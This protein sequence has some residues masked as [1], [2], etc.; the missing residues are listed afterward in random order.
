MLALSE[1]AAQV[2]PLGRRLLKLVTVGLAVTGRLSQVQTDSNCLYKLSKRLCSF[3]SA[4]DS[5]STTRRR[6]GTSTF[7]KRLPSIPTLVFLASATG[8]DMVRHDES[9]SPQS[10]CIP[11]L[12]LSCRSAYISWNRKRMEN[13]LHALSYHSLP[14]GHQD[15]QRMYMAHPVPKFRKIHLAE[16]WHQH[17]TIWSRHQSKSEH[18]KI[19]KLHCPLTFTCLHCHA[20]QCPKMWA[21]SAG[22]A[23]RST[24]HRL[25]PQRAIA[26][27]TAIKMAKD[28]LSTNSSTRRPL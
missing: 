23:K 16:S 15:T 3:Q 21:T 28:G 10:T 7:Q 12:C 13:Q 22:G 11:S 5:D 17:L 14:A 20:I 9:L 24:S 2:L 27:S 8:I 4:S 19:W 6:Q 1:A 25:G 18:P 26:G